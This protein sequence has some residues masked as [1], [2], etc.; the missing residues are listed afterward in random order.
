MGRFQAAQHNQHIITTI[1]LSIQRCPSGTQICVLHKWDLF[2]LYN[3]AACKMN[4]L[5]IN[6]SQ[7]ERYQTK[8]KTQT[9]KPK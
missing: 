5:V 8:G 9:E 2:T 6:Y 7:K 4:I 1:C 3:I